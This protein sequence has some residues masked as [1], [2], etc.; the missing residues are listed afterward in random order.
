[1]SGSSTRRA[2][3]FVRSCRVPESG[4]YSSVAGGAATLYGTAYALSAL[5]YLGVDE[6]VSESTRDFMLESQDL[7]SGY[8]VGP[9]LSSWSPEP[10][11]KHDRE[12]LLMHL[13][14]ATLP[15][16]QQ[17]GLK[18]KSP[19]K[20]ARAFC[21][22]EFLA[23][24]LDR[25]DMSD[26]WLEGN[27]LL[28]IGQFLVYLRDVER[29]P[30][31]D[32]ALAQWFEWLDAHVEP[33]TG[34]W[35]AREAGTFSAMCGGYHQLL[36]YY[37]EQHT[38][39]YADRLVDAVLGLQH[40]DGGF[41][42]LGGGG[43][44]EDAD[45]VDILVNLYKRFD[46]RRK[47]I[48]KALWVCR[49]LIHATQGRDG[50]FPYKL[51]REQDHLGIPDTRAGENEST[52]FATWFRVHTLGLIGQVLGTEPGIRFNRALSM[53]WHDASIR[54][55]PAGAL[56]IADAM[57]VRLVPALK[58]TWIGRRAWRLAKRLGVK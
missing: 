35:G 5:Y 15:V 40:S 6:P 57:R 37:Y 52:M 19:L 13:A 16:I 27:N 44:C 12:H 28:F 22:R 18:A 7:E 2:A 54:V 41:S 30:G 1:M 33:E 49:D 3:D 21:D 11:V 42:P 32:L 58:R 10:G 45:G 47:D 26:P 36:A 56:D 14:S 50:G 8:F 31:A 43:A 48:R 9:E 23:G 39:P 25:R 46:Y 55:P 38:V 17:F 53:G 34:L 51:G 4:G 29:Y 24:W 20:F